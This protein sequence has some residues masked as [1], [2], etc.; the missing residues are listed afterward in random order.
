M[1][2]GSIPKSLVECNGNSHSQ[3][4]KEQIR[5][6]QLQTHILYKHHEQGIGKNHQQKT[7]L[8]PRIN[9]PYFQTPVRLQA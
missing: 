5:N 7:H 6:K 3:I 1:V 8:V 2:T 9:Q 4:K